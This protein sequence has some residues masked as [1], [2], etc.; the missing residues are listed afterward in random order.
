M[1]TDLVGKSEA[2]IRTYLK[3]AYGVAA[4]RVTLSPFWITKM[5]KN[6]EKVRFQ[7]LYK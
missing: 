7:L 5:P 3:S 4:A 1:I 2:D 6:E